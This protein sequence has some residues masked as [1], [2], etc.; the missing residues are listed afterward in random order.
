ME[1][2]RENPLIPGQGCT[3]Q[4]AVRTNFVFLPTQEAHSKGQSHSK[5]RVYTESKP[6]VTLLVM[7]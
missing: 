3:N 7:R 6:S 1:Q 2:Y 4:I 5:G